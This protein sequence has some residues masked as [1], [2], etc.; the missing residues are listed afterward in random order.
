MTKWFCSQT[1]FGKPELRKTARL[2][3]ANLLKSELNIVHCYLSIAN[4][5]FVNLYYS[6][7]RK[8]PATSFN[9]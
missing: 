6:P 5:H 2:I 4:S 3:K 1:V 8:L 7:A 9:T